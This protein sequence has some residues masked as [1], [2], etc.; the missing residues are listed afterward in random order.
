MNICKD[1]H[2]YY[3]NFINMTFLFLFKCLKILPGNNFSLFF[4][5]LSYF[6][7]FQFSVSYRIE[8]IL[9]HFMITTF[10]EIFHYTEYLEAYILIGYSIQLMDNFFMYYVQCT[11]CTFLHV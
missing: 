3:F 9:A 4:L 2:M 5:S 10:I 8:C 6:W 1:G 11:S 7:K